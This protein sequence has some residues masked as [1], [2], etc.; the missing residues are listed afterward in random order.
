M[1]AEPNGPRA[2]VLC[3]GE[4]HLAR[5]GPPVASRIGA[6]HLALA[7][8]R[9]SEQ[10]ARALAESISC[11]AARASCGMRVGNGHLAPQQQQQQLQQQEQQL[12]APR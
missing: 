5:V 11:S 6:C 7:P 3:V 1:S 12:Q 4:V 9:P 2:G 8:R 10:Q